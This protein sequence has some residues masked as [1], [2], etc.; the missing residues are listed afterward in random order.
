ML[1]LDSLIAQAE[2]E[3]GLDPAVVAARSPGARVSGLLKI[4][5]HSRGAVWTP[6]EEQFLA[7]N[8]GFMDEQELA[9]ALGRT[10]PAIKIRRYRHLELAA[11]GHGHRFL[12]A[13]R[14][15]HALGI[16]GHTTVKLVDRGL[17]PAWRYSHRQIRLA[18]RSTFLRWAVNPM[19]WPYFLRS[20]RDTSRLND[21]HL[22]RLV[23]RQKSRWKDEWWSTGQ[24]ADYHGIHHTDVNRAV[25]AGRIA[26]LKFGNWWILRSEATRPGL[27]FSTGSGS[28]GH[29]WSEE[30][31]CFILIGVALGVKQEALAALMDWPVRT[32]SSRLR[33]LR[34]RGHIPDLVAKYG[35]K[36]YY[37]PRT[38]QLDGSWAD[39]GYKFPRLKL[40]ATRSTRGAARLQRRRRSR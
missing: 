29:D 19:H 27:F 22:R 20:V 37:D 8:I 23:E 33:A 10:V 14:M 3:T 39:Y 21:D 4:P 36:L 32:V 31:D 26:G 16:D 13:N 12:S 11:P 34:Q 30:A 6:A 1:D 28:G 7:E 15:A 9:E 2:L 25:H 35:L 17:L 18:R 40:V 5:G 24:V 38:G